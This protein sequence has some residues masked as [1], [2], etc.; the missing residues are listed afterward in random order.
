MFTKL[1]IV[2]PTRNSAEFLPYTL[3]ALHPAIANSQADVFVFDQSS[4]D[5]T[6]G[7]VRRFPSIY[8]Y[9]Q[10]NTFAECGEAEM[11]NRALNI[12]RDTGQYSHFM[13]IDSD[14]LIVDGWFSQL[15]RLINA[16][17]PG[18]IKSPYYQLIGVPWLGQMGNPIEQRRI[19][20]RLTNRIEWL[21]RPEAN[22][23]CYTRHEGPIVEA[24]D[25]L[26]YIHLG[27]CRRDMRQ[28]LVDNI[29]RG[30]WNLG[31][32]IIEDYVKDVQ[33]NPWSYLPEVSG[34][35]MEM[36]TRSKALRI[37][38]QLY[39]HLNFKVQLRTTNKGHF[40]IQ[41]ITYGT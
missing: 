40:K 31:P 8:W 28:R 39:K 12:V 27:Y 38:Y 36:R 10:I 14:E 30:D 1:A 15:L 34:F 26:A 25:A 6:Y 41:D 11:R 20:Y 7:I 33:V 18:C 4:T 2:I 13:Q 29:R 35:P 5:D 21:S 16:H 24:G 32:N 19:V 9:Q 17:D 37:L 22:Y 3:Q 23:H